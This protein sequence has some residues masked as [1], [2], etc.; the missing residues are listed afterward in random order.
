MQTGSSAPAVC[1][2]GW[3]MKFPMVGG[4]SCADEVGC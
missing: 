3:S 4:G 2:L 1:E